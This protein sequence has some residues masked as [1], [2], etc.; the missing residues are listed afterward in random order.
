[1]SWHSDSG[2]VDAHAI[3]SWV[4]DTIADR[5]AHNPSE[6][7][8]DPI[9][10][11]D[12]ALRRVCLVRSPFGFYSLSN[13]GPITWTP[14]GGNASIPWTSVTG[15][16]GDFSRAE[17]LTYTDTAN[18]VIGPLATPPVV[19]ELS[20]WPLG[21]VVQEYGVDFTVRQV[22]GGGAPGYYIC[23]STSSTAPGGGTFLSGSNPST[24]IDTLLSSGDKTQ[25][26]YPTY[27]AP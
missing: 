20:L 14:F 13:F 19:N 8:T 3:Q 9:T 21:G 22:T 24:G 23:L 25:A 1:M 2:P 6:G 7:E 27:P 18:K 12:A 4:Y 26:V 17:L 15:K 16:P 5:D 10:A 11:A